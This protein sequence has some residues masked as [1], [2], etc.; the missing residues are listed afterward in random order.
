METAA[1][2]FERPGQLGIKRL[3]LSAPDRSDVVV[4][5]LW[6]GISTGT[7]KMLFDGSMPSFPGMGYPLVP[8]YES[9][10]RIVEAGPQSGRRVGE[11]VF[12]PGANCFADAAGLFGATASRLVVPG[13]R[14]IPIAADMED[15]AVLLALAATAHHAVAKAERPVGLVVGHGVL[16]RLIARIVIA[17][18]YEPPTVWETSSERRNGADGYAALNPS[19]DDTKVYGAAIDASGNVSVVDRVIQRLGKG[20]ELVLAG[21]YS[22][23][24]S[25]DFAPAFMREVTLSIAAEFK[26]DD[27][28][29]VL[30]L[31]RDGRLS[32]KGLIT[33]RSAPADAET[34]YTTAFRDPACLKMVIDWRNAA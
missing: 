31:V 14:T 11:T 12:V 7:E 34:A 5:T 13:S 3:T 4:E 6:S 9:V 8:G 16:G 27:V 21:F 1:V 33:H 30:N 22:D 28:F 2:V 24:V 18:G 25:F 15:D 29:A 10:A 20:G 19:D 17:L 32:L 23:R 26:P